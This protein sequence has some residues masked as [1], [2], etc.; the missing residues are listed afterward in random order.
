LLGARYALFERILHEA[1]PRK[2]FRDERK[3][4]KFI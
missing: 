4:P 3:N 1:P 2:R